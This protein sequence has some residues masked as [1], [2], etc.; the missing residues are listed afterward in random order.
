MCLV[1]QKLQCVD[2][3]ESCLKLFRLSKFGS[4]SFQNHIDCRMCGQKTV[5]KQRYGS[6]ILGYTCNHLI[7]FIDYLE[8]SQKINS[9]RYVNKLMCLKWE[10]VKTELICRRRKLHFQQDCELCHKAIRTMIKIHELRSE[11]F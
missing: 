3:S 11:R 8:E 1:N 4:T 9:D 2:E 10:I 6:H 5:S 7:W